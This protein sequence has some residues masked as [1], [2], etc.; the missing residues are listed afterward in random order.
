MSWALG[1]KGF[2]VLFA[3]P[4][5]EA[6]AEPPVVVTTTR[7]NDQP[8][9]VDAPGRSAPNPYVVTTPA[10][11]PT[12]PQVV[13]VKSG[14]PGA[15]P[16]PSLGSLDTD[17]CRAYLAQLDARIDALRQALRS[18]ND[19]GD[20]AAADAL[21][22]QLEDD[23]RYR[24]TER[25]RLMVSDWAMVVGGGVTLGL[26]LL[27]LPTSLG[28]ALASWNDSNEAYDIAAGTLGI[29]GLVAIPIGAVLVAVGKGHRSARVEPASA[30]LRPTIGLGG[31]GFQIAF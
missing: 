5:I 26:G 7:T 19:A 4:A 28:F 13:I 31:A 9:V 20:D 30:T 15:I 14:A 24:T 8:I 21:R 1:W 10:G 23:Q 17:G 11:A 16:P 18:A 6:R 25:D 3:F 27:A 22:T 12:G 29:T 2:A